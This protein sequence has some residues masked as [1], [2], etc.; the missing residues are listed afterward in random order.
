[1]RAWSSSLRSFLSSS[2]RRSSSC[3]QRV[4]GRLVF[5][6][7]N[8]RGDNVFQ[9]M[10]F[11]EVAQRAFAGDGL[12]TAHAAGDASFFQNF[13]QADFAGRR[14]VRAAAEFG[15]EVADA[16]DA[17]VVAV[18]LAEERH[19][20]VFVDGNIDGNVFNDLDAIVAQDFFI[21]EV[22][23]VLQFFVAE[24]GEVGEVKAQVRGIDQRS[25]LL[26]V[27]PSTSR[28]AA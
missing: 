9:L 26:D 17:N 23:D 25:R 6:A 16:N 24:R 5:A 21:G 10:V 4:G 22:F 13:D 28:S 18:L 3:L 1:M 27:R 8:Q 11:A 20:L 19:G 7:A 15:G 2:S 14:G 12:E